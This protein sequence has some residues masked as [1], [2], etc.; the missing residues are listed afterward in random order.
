MQYLI[1]EFAS[2]AEMREVAKK[3]WDG[4]GITGEM[5]MHPVVGGK[6]RLEIASE[7]ELRDSTLEKF[8]QYR[9]EAGD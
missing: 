6:W 8:A 2:E 1:F 9:V 5:H 4:H 3:L 7:K